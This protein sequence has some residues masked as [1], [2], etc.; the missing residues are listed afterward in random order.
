MTYENYLVE[1]L[2]V[3]RI[4]LASFVDRLCLC[5][6]Y[7]SNYSSPKFI[8]EVFSEEVIGELERTMV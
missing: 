6:N 5:S 3:G 2:N 7:Y 8:E 4:E 1:S